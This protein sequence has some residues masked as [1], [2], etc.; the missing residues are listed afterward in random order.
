MRGN[1]HSSFSRPGTCLPNAPSRVQH[2]QATSGAAKRSQRFSVTAHQLTITSTSEPGLGN[3][4]RRTSKQ[5]AK[6]I[7]WW[8][9]KQTVAEFKLL[10][11]V[12]KHFPVG[13]TKSMSKTATF[14]WNTCWTHAFDVSLSAALWSVS[15]SFGQFQAQEVSCSRFIDARSSPSDHSPKEHVRQASA[16]KVIS[17]SLQ[18]P[19]QL[20][21][22]VPPL[23]H[24]RWHSNWAAY[25]PTPEPI[26]CH[27]ELHM[28]ANDDPNCFSTQPRMSSVGSASA[29][30]SAAISPMVVKVREHATP[31]SVRST[32]K[33]CNCCCLAFALPNSSRL[34]KLSLLTVT[35]LAN[36]DSCFFFLFIG[37]LST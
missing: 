16:D 24:V 20:V 7:G 29:T 25:Q 35:G 2:S 19:H 34:R 1:Q 8:S 6:L 15:T 30:R 10:I 33:V 3:L 18:D 11:T 26:P 32:W 22:R 12:F 21:R 23:N 28:H 37:L 17:P 14:P 13:Y 4:F 9:L 31:L 36:Q 27:D 5:V